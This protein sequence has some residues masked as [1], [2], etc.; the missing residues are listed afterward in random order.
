MFFQYNY[1]LKKSLNSLFQKSPHQTSKVSK[2][3]KI[4]VVYQISVQDEIKREPDYLDINEEEVTTSSIASSNND[5]M[6]YLFWDKSA[7]GESSLPGIDITD[8]KQLIDFTRFQYFFFLINIIIF[9]YLQLSLLILFK[10]HMLVT[11]KNIFK[12]QNLTYKRIFTE[13]YLV[14]TK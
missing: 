5:C 2:S 12:E 14:L 8:P 11:N 13:L 10:I 4:F 3:Y 6:D 9:A 7:S 1:L